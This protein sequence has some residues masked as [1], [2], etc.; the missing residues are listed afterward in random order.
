VYFFGFN[1]LPLYPKTEIVTQDSEFEDEFED[2]FIDS[3]EEEFDQ[4][5]LEYQNGYYHTNGY[6]LAGFY[7][8]PNLCTKD[9]KDGATFAPVFEP[10]DP[11]FISQLYLFLSSI[12]CYLMEICQNVQRKRRFGQDANGEVDDNAW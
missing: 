9:P 3:E 10:K 12:Q 1:F 2:E 6:G 11:A 5:E 8:A 4:A 7:P